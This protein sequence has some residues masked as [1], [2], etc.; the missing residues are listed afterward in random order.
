MLKLIILGKLGEVIFLVETEDNN[1]RELQ[2]L[3]AFILKTNE[4]FGRS[5][6]PRGLRLGSAAASLLEF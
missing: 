1:F 5:Q 6:R 3:F 4:L 2:R